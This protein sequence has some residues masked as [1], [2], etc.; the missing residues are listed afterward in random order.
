MSERFDDSLD[1]TEHRGSEATDESEARDRRLSE[2]AL[3]N[4]HEMDT[5]LN[6][7]F[8]GSLDPPDESGATDAHE[9][10]WDLGTA[11]SDDAR[12]HSHISQASETGKPGIP[13]SDLTGTTEE[14]TGPGANI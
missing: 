8:I 14:T 6:R 1:S 13:N 9:S 4:S 11:T 3:P 12:P 2:S 5:N 7:P 10:P